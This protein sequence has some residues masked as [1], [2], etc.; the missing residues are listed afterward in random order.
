MAGSE[1]ARRLLAAGRAAMP[2]GWCGRQQGRAKC[3][4]TKAGLLTQV[5]PWTAWRC[6]AGA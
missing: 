5:R 1:A 4:Y 6:G 3:F 2:A